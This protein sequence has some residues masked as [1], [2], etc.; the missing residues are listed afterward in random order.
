MPT[1]KHLL[2]KW[3]LFCEAGSAYE[4]HLFREQCLFS[5]C[6]SEKI[7]NLGHLSGI[8]S[9]DSAYAVETSVSSFCRR[10][11]PEKQTARNEAPG[12]DSK[13]SS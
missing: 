2:N 8:M 4:Q 9:P 7:T 5:K 6:Y 13:T 11:C 3:Q 1:E 12:E 10:A